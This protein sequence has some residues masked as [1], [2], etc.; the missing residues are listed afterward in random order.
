MLK[1]TDRGMQNKKIKTD[2]DDIGYRRQQ[3]DDV[4]SK[5][6]EDG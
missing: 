1:Q 2:E 6:K 4:Y 3:G 5:E